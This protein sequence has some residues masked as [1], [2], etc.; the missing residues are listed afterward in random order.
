MAK[1]SI[2]VVRTA[3]DALEEQ[4]LQSQG[5]MTTSVRA[6]Y[7]EQEVVA[8]RQMELASKLR[9]EVAQPLAYARH[10]R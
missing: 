8:M 10:G 6:I 9:T 4:K 2:R 1:A 7:T 5:T 3:L